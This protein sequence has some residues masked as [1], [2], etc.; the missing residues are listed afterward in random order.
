MS[1]VIGIAAS[2]GGWAVTDKTLYGRRKQR[3]CVFCDRAGALFSCLLPKADGCAPWALAILLELLDR[4]VFGVVE[5][6]DVVQGANSASVRPGDDGSLDDALIRS[7]NAGLDRFESG[8]PAM[9]R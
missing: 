6:G 5:E 7:A 3:P 1:G 2:G 9:L 4:V 8:P